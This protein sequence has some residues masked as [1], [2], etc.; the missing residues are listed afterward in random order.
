[1]QNNNNGV[2]II[3][4]TQIPISEIMSIGKAFVDSGMFPDIKSAAMAV[5]KIQAGQE[6]GIAPFAAMTGIH[7]IQGRPTIGAGLI[8]SKIKSSGKYNY[9]IIKHDKTVCDIEFFEGKEALGKSTFTLDDARK[10]G[11]KNLDK[12]PENMLFARAISNGVKWFCPD[13]FSGPVYTPE[14]MESIPQTTED[15]THEEVKE[16]ATPPPV[17][18]KETPPPVINNGDGKKVEKITPAVQGQKPWLNPNTKEWNNAFAKIH[19]GQIDMNDVLAN[20]RISKANHENLL[21]PNYVY[22]PTNYEK[23]QPAAK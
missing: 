20:Y 4:Q 12:F 14:E 22:E 21:N 6:I 2:A 13:V 1:M 11:T 10:A 16:P 8:A 19:A 15:V 18:P 17:L 7:I 9:K 23:F 3:K 5:V